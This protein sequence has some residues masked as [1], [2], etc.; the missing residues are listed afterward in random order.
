MVNSLLQ[1][2]RKNRYMLVHKPG[3][4]P[5][6][7][8]QIVG[9]EFLPLAIEQQIS[10][11]QKLRGSLFVLYSCPCEE[12][13]ELWFSSLYFYSATKKV[14]ALVLPG[15]VKKIDYNDK[16][17]LMLVL[18]CNIATDC[19]S[20][21]CEVWF[22]DCKTLK[23]VNKFRRDTGLALVRLEV[24]SARFSPSGRHVLLVTKGPTF[25]IYRIKEGLWL[26]H[27]RLFVHPEDFFNCYYQPE[28]DWYDAEFVSYGVDQKKLAT[29]DLENF[30]ANEEDSEAPLLVDARLWEGIVLH[31]KQEEKDLKEHFK[32]KVIREALI[33]GYRMNPFDDPKNLRDYF[34]LPSPVVWL[35]SMPR[36]SRLY[37]QTHKR[38]ISFNWHKYKDLR[39]KGGYEY[40]DEL[41]IPKGWIS[42]SQDEDYISSAKIKSYKAQI[43]KIVNNNSGEPI[44]QFTNCFGFFLA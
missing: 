32:N 31:N 40:A 14:D 16:S 37:V 33:P 28:G 7:P 26:Y 5:T 2:I 41:H 18:L 20:S 27:V 17:Q 39:E 4:A 21:N 30:D 12:I 19:I 43:W 23:A 29:L 44:C 38:L 11:F 1:P 13:Y 3:S 10:G 22:Y 34:E 6:L 15:F 36:S 24:D 42:I 9:I 35:K 8:T 25:E